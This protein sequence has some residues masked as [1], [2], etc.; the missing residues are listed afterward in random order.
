MT[1]R[2]AFI[3]EDDVE[4]ADCLELMAKNAGISQ[5][6]RF[7][8]VI[9]AI[10][11]T[12]E[13]LPDVILLD[14]LLTGPNGFALLNELASYS[15]TA[16]IPIILLSSLNFVGRD[17]GAY[18]IVQIFDKAEMRPTE[19]MAAIKNAVELTYAS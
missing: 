12:N 10:E 1:S 9:S 19:I 14:V 11:A 3:I 6:F 4:M 15:D 16:R 2:I 5:I 13:V 18:N 7:E 8:E 17:L